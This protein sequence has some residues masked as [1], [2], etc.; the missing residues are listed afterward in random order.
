MLWDT[1]CMTPL[2]VQTY[3]LLSFGNGFQ[4]DDYANNIDEFGIW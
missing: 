1:C 4:A 3:S 2:Y